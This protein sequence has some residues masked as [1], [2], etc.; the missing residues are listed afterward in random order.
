[1]VI[2]SPLLYMD[3]I[4]CSV[5]FF[6]AMAGE[7]PIGE[8]E[9]YRTCAGGGTIWWF[10]TVLGNNDDH[11]CDTKGDDVVLMPVVAVRD[12]IDRAVLLKARDMFGFAVVMDSLISG[13]AGNEM[14]GQPLQ[15]GWR[16]RVLVFLDWYKSYV[17]VQIPWC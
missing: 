13:S 1:M 15:S 17:E 16:D 8:C 4:V 3:C 12:D 7:V 6:R 11:E 9:E 14:T 5:T 2:G 10:T